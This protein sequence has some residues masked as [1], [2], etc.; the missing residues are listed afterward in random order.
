MVITYLMHQPG[1]VASPARGQ[2][3]RIMFFLLSPF[4]G[5]ENLVSRDGFGRPVP[6]P[7]D[8]PRCAYLVPPVI[9]KKND[10]ELNV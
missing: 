8:K 2:L 10:E 6:R 4:A 5:P 7:E 1:M 3:N 9:Y